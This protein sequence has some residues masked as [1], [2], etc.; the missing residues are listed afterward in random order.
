[1][2]ASRQR[3]REEEAAL[4]LRRLLLVL[5]LTLILWTRVGV[6]LL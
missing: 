4:W 2:P 6:A 5:M 1:M 3:L